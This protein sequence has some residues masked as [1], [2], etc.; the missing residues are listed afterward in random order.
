MNKLIKNSLTTAFVAAMAVSATACEMT[1]SD[2]GSKSKTEPK[3]DPV[4]NIFS[5]QKLDKGI[6][7]AEAKE[8]KCGEGK[9]GADKMKMKAAKAAEAVVPETVEVKEAVEAVEEKAEAVKE[10]TAE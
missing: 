6:Q 9:C 8:G 4:A 5:I 2:S 3:V 1:E 10:D 7:V